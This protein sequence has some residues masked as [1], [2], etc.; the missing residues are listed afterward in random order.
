[1]VSFIILAHVGRRRRA[2]TWTGGG[3]LDDQVSGSSGV[4][5]VQAKQK[6]LAKSPG[7]SVGCKTSLFMAM[8]QLSGGREHCGSSMKASFLW[9][10]T[11][12]SYGE[13]P[14][15]PW[16]LS[17]VT[18][19]WSLTLSEPQLLLSFFLRFVFPSVLS[20]FL[21]FFAFN[22]GLKLTVLTSGSVWGTICDTRHKNATFSLNSS[23]PFIH[24]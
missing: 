10:G 18:W 12:R 6:L 1:M 4:P 3:A 11:H 21:F 13:G 22:F 7:M 19:I 20:F 14:S 15:H 23:H 17:C 5:C 16:S 8:V 24:Y 9:P 2:G